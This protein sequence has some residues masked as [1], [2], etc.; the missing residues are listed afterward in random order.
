MSR[1]LWERGVGADE[2]PKALR[3]AGLIATLGGLCWGVGIAAVSAL[4][5]VLGAGLYLVLYGVAHLPLLLSERD[6]A[7]ARPGRVAWLITVGLCLA[8]AL[9]WT[10]WSVAHAR[11]D[12]APLDLWAYGSLLLIGGAMVI[13]A[14]I[15]L[16]G[17]LMSRL[18]ALT[19]LGASVPVVVTGYLWMLATQ[20]RARVLSDPHADVTVEAVLAWICGLFFA[21]GWGAYGLGLLQRA[22]IVTERMARRAGVPASQ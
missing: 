10:V 20:E 7:L 11:F 19:L 3:R 15:L 6:Q 8:S 14:M 18:Y 2:A 12:L 5:V 9:T 22:E 13:V 21:A 4:Y 16:A 1:V 17:R